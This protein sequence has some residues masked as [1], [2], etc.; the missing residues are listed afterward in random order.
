VKLKKRMG[1]DAKEERGGE[2]ERR[3]NASAM[4]SSER[5]E[6]KNTS[7][8]SKSKGCLPLKKDPGHDEKE[9][10]KGKNI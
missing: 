7:G 4:L 5:G 1:N 9:T 8:G 6:G 3:G 10:E 2:G